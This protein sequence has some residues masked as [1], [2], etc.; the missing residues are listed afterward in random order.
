MCRKPLRQQID[1]AAHRRREMMAMWIQRID[2]EFDR[3][4]VLEQ[5]YEAAAI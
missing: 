5:S 1:E 2:R 4:D 3:R